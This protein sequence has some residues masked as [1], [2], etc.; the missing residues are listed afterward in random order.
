MILVR[1]WLRKHFINQSLA[2]LRSGIPV[3]VFIDCQMQLLDGLR[4]EF[5][6]EESEEVWGRY[7]H[8]LIV[9]PSGY[10]LF[11]K[12]NQPL[13]VVLCFRLLRPGSRF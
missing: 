1:R 8:Q 5:L 11:Q 10:R 12:V 9:V 4:A 3:Q 13:R 6:F 7:E 2:N